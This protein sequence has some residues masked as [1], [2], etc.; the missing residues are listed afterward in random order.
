MPG[1]ISEHRVDVLCGDQ[2]IE[3]GIK[4]FGRCAADPFSVHRRQFSE[5]QSRLTQ[6]R[7]CLALGDPGGLALGDPGGLALGDPD[8]LALGDPGGLALFHPDLRGGTHHV[9]H[10]LRVRPRPPQRGLDALGRQADLLN[11][12]SQYVATELRLRNSGLRNGSDSP[13]A[14]FFGDQG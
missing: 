12:V 6:K 11:D 3:P 14:R 1:T 8:G 10:R 2:G 13:M 9:L 7:L 4:L 5:L